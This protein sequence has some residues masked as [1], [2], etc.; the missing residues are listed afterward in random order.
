MDAPFLPNIEGIAKIP[1]I[2]IGDE[3][4]R[5]FRAFFERMGVALKY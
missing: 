4:G 5:S 1:P 3:R 2:L